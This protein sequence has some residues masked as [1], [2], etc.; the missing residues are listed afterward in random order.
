MHRVSGRGV[1]GGGGNMIQNHILLQASVIN[2][3]RLH[4]RAWQLLVTYHIVA[5]ITSFCAFLVVNPDHYKDLTP[6]KHLLWLP[7]GTM[8]SRLC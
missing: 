4:R 1:G 2:N 8:Q 6:A 5:T 3:C 7:E